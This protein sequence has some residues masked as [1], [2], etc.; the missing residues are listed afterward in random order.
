MIFD[1]DK[2]VRLRHQIPSNLLNRSHYQPSVDPQEETYPYSIKMT[3]LTMLFEAFLF[4]FSNILEIIEEVYLFAES[5]FDRQRDFEGV[6]AFIH[7]SL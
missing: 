3:Y 7:V 4:V 1:L 5:H 2:I 6:D